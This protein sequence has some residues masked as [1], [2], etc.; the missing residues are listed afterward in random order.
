MPPKKI[1]DIYR[2]VILYTK[3]RYANSHNE[4]NDLRT[5]IARYDGLEQENENLID[6]FK[7]YM[8]LVN[9]LCEIAD[10]EA[11]R[12]LL[13]NFFYKPLSKPEPLIIE[14]AIYEMTQILSVIK[15]RQGDEILLDLGE[16]DYKLLPKHPEYL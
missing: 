5:L 1:Y 9:T 13:Y 2:H 16:P 8:I 10:N 11:I 15:V 14:K 4:L 12:K 6:D 7:I 3:S